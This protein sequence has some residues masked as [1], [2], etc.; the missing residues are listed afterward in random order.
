MSKDIYRALCAKQKDIPV[1]SQ[2]WWLDAV[3]GDD[4]KVLLY[5]K[6]GVILA[7]MPLFIPAKRIVTMPHYTQTMGVWFAGESN[8]T[9]YSSRLEQR[10]SI[11]SIFIQ[12]LTSYRSFLQ[13]FYHSFTDWLPFYWKGYAQTTRYTY[14]LHNIKDFEKIENGMNQQARR[15]IRSAK[16]AKI[17]FCRGIPTEQLLT[18]QEQSFQ[19]QQ[20]KNKQSDAVL[21]RLIETAR[22]RGQGD[23][24]G[25]YDEAGTL[26]AAAFIVWQDSSAHYIAGGGDPALRQSGAHS[27]VMW[28]AIQYVSQFTDKFDFDGSMI[29][30]VEFFFRSFGAVQTPYFTIS[31]GKLSIIDRMRIKIKSQCL[32]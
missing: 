15:N 24:F 5:E 30:G 31:R 7:A 2:D 12:E 4:W 16:T 23:I 11:C 1:F 28:E 3:C 6:K 13:Y 8:D 18:I 21:C 27:L 29:S 32:K 26:H 19:R 22:K 20:I 14:I 17:R 10:Q 25:G 9:K